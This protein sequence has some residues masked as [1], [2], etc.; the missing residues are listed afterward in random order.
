MH[1]ICSADTSLYTWKA[2]HQAATSFLKPAR[3]RQKSFA[4][5]SPLLSQ[6]WLQQ[7]RGCSSALR[8]LPPFLPQPV[9]LGPHAFGLGAGFALAF[10][11][12]G[13]LCSAGCQTAAAAVAEVSGHCAHMTRLMTTTGRGRRESKRIEINDLLY[14][15]RT[16]YSANLLLLILS[17]NLIH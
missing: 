10:L 4:A 12:P 2:L 5:E 13:L 14:Q 3:N 15:E 6:L 9:P 11:L 1:Q 7:S 8:A 17:H 16:N